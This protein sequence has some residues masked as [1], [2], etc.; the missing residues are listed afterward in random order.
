MEGGKQLWVLTYCRL[1]FVGGWSSSYMAMF[2][3]G[4]SPSYT[5][6]RFCTQ[7]TVFIRGWSSSY[8]G[9]RGSYSCCDG[10]GCGGYGAHARVRGGAGCRCG[11]GHMLVV[12]HKEEG[13]G[14]SNDSPGCVDGDDGKHCHHLDDVARCHIV[15]IRCGRPQL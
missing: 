1:A 15:T 5:G 7:A 12:W 8:V 13:G 11:R 2:R 9:G 4:W 14:E 6:D 3:C 10:R